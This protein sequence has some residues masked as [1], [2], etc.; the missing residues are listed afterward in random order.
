MTARYIITV[1]RSRI[2]KGESRPIRV[3]AV[4]SGSVQHVDRVAL[5]GRVVVQHGLPRQDGARVWIEADG[6][7]L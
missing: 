7:A 6:V 1:D 4:R 2:D 3:E 5:T